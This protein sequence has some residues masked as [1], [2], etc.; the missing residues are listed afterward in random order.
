MAVLQPLPPTKAELR[1]TTTTR[2]GGVNEWQVTLPLTNPSDGV[3]SIHTWHL[4]L[5]PTY[6]LHGHTAPHWSRFHR[7]LHHPVSAAILRPAPLPMRE[8]TTSSL[9]ARYVRRPDDNSYSLFPPPCLSLQLSAQ[10]KG[11]HTPVLSGDH[12]GPSKARCR[13]LLPPGGFRVACRPCYMSLH[14]RRPETSN[15]A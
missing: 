5:S 15:H 10:R 4:R 14:T 3:P 1:A 8:P 9:A 2:E 7:R 13:E 6:F 11:L 12:P